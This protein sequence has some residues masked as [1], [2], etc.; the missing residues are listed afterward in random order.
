MEKT[1]DKQLVY[2]FFKQHPLV[3]ISTVSKDGVPQNAAVYAYMDEQMN[4]YVVTR[5]HTRKYSNVVARKLAILSA[6]DE[7]VLMFGELTCEASVVDDTEEIASILPELQKII[8]SRKSAYWVA[9]V[10]Q[11]EGENFVFL[12]LKPKKVTFVNYEQSSSDEPKPHQISFE[13]E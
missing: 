7:N 8:A 13:M 11:L 10:A 4:C 3:T 9:P 12:K 5:E 1:P 6:Y 2:S